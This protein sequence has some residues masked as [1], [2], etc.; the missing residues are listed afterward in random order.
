MDLLG[1]DV[2]SLPL[3][4]RPLWNARIDERKMYFF[5]KDY[6]GADGVFQDNRYAMCNNISDACFINSTMHFNQIDP[7]SNDLSEAQ[8]IA[9]DLRS[10]QSLLY[11]WTFQ[12]VQ[13]RLN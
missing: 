11:R 6:F 13:K 2:N 12:G 7:L 10:I 8:T 1:M 3:Q 5:A 9:A 4:G